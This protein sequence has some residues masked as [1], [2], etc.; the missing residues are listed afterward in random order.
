MAQS[1]Q[2]LPSAQVM[3]SG[4]WDRVLGY[5]PCSAGRLLFLLPLPAAPSACAVLVCLL[6]KKLVTVRVRVLVGDRTRSIALNVYSML[7]TATWGGGSLKGLSPGREQEADQ[8]EV[9]PLLP[10]L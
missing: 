10:S 2:H 5:A 9:F 4:S 6:N 1:V 7:V 3:T 8:H